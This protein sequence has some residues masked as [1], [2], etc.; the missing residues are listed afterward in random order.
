MR[1]QLLS[2]LLFCSSMPVYGQEKWAPAFS[3][4]NKEVVAH[5]EAYTQLKKATETIGHRLTGSSNGKKAE[6]LAFSMLKGYGLDVR[7]QPF[8]VESWSRGTL[9]VQVKDAS[10]ANWAP[11][12]SVTL[13]HSP[14]KAAIIGELVDMGNGLEGDYAE[15]PDA[16][17]GK[18][19]LVFIGLLP[20]TPAGTENLHRSEK[21]AIA[22]KYGAK[23]IVIINQVKDGVLLTGTASVTGKLISIPA[24]CIGY[25]DG[26]ALKERVEEQPVQVQVSMTNHSNVIHSRNI[27]A[28]W[29][30]Q[31]YPN[32]KI[33][34]GAHLDSWDLATGATDNGL[35][36]FEVIDM[37]R[38]FKAL[39]LPVDRT[40]EFVLFMGEEEGLLGSRNYVSEALKANTLD[41]VK[42]VINLDMT[43]AAIGFNTGGRKESVPF[44]T[45]V[46]AEIKAL[47][48]TFKNKGGGGAGLH[49]DHEPFMLQGIPTASTINNMPASI[50]RCYHADCDN[51]DLIQPSWMT[52]NVRFGSMLLYALANADHLP[53]E[54]QSDVAT[55]QF[56]MDNNLKTPLQIAGDWRWKE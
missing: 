55:R 47:D 13:A 56:L 45:G 32:E 5:S 41:Q 48:T 49:S 44:F 20:G 15:R 46:G 34:V 40:I 18:V 22:L 17:K 19:A 10:T 37:A 39:K 54:K 52:D 35:G 21:T 12:K 28:T 26:M 50:Y 23:G 27:I 24:I 6:D 2:A 53:A 11:L 43:G 42:Y 3:A 36:S 4:I 31:K 33:V 1:K 38:T 25:E 16:V 51:I 14:V 9:S 29:K 30:G 8:A 7:Y